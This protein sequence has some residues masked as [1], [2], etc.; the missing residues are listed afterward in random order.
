MRLLRRLTLVSLLGFSLLQSGSTLQADEPS[1][2][3]VDLSNLSAW[4]GDAKGWSTASVA[5]LDPQDTKRLAVEPG[6]GIIHNGPVGHVP[7]IVTQQIF[8]DVEVHIEYFL[9][10]NSN[11]GIKFQGVYEIQMFDS[12]GKQKTTGSDNGGVYP[13]SELKPKYHHID[14][15]HAPLVNAS[16]APGEW[17]T[18]DATFIAPRFDDA[19]NKVADARISATLNGQKIQD[20]LKVMTPTGNAHHDKEKPNGPLL[21]QADHGPVAFRN[22]RARPIAA[23]GSH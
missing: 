1:A 6:S 14:D 3:W 17:Q 13:R 8:G 9:P 15:G 21:L 19:G 10:K 22:I 18:L 2:G 7:N 4:K 11:S 12:F 23:V 5:K 20:D 16:L